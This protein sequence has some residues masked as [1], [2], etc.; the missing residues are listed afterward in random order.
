MT[1]LIFAVYKFSANT[2][3]PVNGWFLGL[4]QRMAPYLLLTFEGLFP[5]VGPVERLYEP[6]ADDSQNGAR[7]QLD[8]D[9][10]DP[11]V[12][13]VQQLVVFLSHPTHPHMIQDNKFAFL[14]NHRRLYLE[15]EVRRNA[16]YQRQR[17]A[18]TNR[19]VTSSVGAEDMASLWKPETII[20]K[21]Q[22]GVK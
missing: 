9:T 10:V 22:R 21:H 1:K 16:N 18:D 14:Q 12:N 3:G 6:A 2:E 13:V 11:E 8:D 20:G 4:P 19:Q 17:V 7:Q 15:H 5:A